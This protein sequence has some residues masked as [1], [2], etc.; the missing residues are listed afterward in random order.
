MKEIERKWIVETDALP[1][2]VRDGR[3]C[4]IEQAYVA[5][6]PDGPEVRIRRTDDAMTLTVK[7]KGGLVRTEV[8]VEIDAAQFEALM[9]VAGARRLTK[10]RYFVDVSGHEAS[11]DVYDGTLAGMVIAEVEFASESA[12]NAFDA[13]AWFGRDVTDDAQYRNRALVLMQRDG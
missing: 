11:V 9:S 1:A 5:L 13:P 6:E 10:T 7:S 12:A 8:D 4:R 3:S 2:V